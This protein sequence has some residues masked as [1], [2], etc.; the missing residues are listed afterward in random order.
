MRAI[1]ERP[2][3]R[4]QHRCTGPRRTADGCPGRSRHPEV[5][6]AHSTARGAGALDRLVVYDTQGH[7]LLDPATRDHLEILRGARGRR[8]GSLL[9]AL[10][11][12]ALR[13]APVPWRDGWGTRCST[14]RRLKRASTASRCWWAIIASGS[15]SN[16]PWTRCLTW[17]GSPGRAAQRLL[18][19]REALPGGGPEVRRARASVGSTRRR[20]R[21]DRRAH[22]SSNRARRRDHRAGGHGSALA[23][24]E[25]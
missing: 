23:F 21:P 16:N 14:G 24:G 8:E 15:S 17:S 9:Q 22:R 12:L 3:R 5:P 25:G 4:G 19:P 6:R 11:T 13:W 2:L 20:T 10:D 7:M 18:T 1:A